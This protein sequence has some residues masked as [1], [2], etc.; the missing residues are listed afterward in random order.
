MIQDIW[1]IFRTDGLKE[2]EIE[3]D[4]EI[5]KIIESYYELNGYR[6]KTVSM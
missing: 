4:L 1:S 6:V 3:V 2:I 5:L